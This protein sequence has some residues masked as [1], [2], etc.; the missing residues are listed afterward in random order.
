MI[1]AVAHLKPAVFAHL[2]VSARRCTVKL[3]ALLASSRK[4]AVCG[5]SDS[6]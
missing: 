3:D 1:L 2:P 5:G 6:P 4:P